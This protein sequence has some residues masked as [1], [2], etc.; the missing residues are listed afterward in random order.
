L[1]ETGLFP[2][3]SRVAQVKVTGEAAKGYFGLVS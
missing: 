1:S 3:G 2:D